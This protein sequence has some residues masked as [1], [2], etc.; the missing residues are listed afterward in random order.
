MYD[1]VEMRLL[2][3]RNSLTPEIE[4]VIADVRSLQPSIKYTR[5]ANYGARVDL[6]EVM[7][8]DAMLHVCSLN[9]KGNHKLELLHTGTK[10]WDQMMT[11]V[12]RVVRD[13]FESLEIMR[14]DPC[15]DI[16]DV[17]MDWF[18]RSVRC[19]RKRWEQQFGK[20]QVEDGQPVDVDYRD[21]SKK[22]RETIYLGRDDNFVR[23]YD[24]NA[25]TQF[26]YKREERQ[27]YRRAE[28]V[29]AQAVVA[30]NVGLSADRDYM[31][32][33]AKRV[34]ESAAR[35]YPFPAYEEWSGMWKW[36]V[37][38]RVE[39]Q[40]R[41]T[42]PLTLSK[43]GMVRDNALSFNPFD[44]MRF[45]PPREF[46]LDELRGDY[47]PAQLLKV[48][49]AWYLLNIEGWSYHE[50]F[51]FMNMKRNGRQFEQKFGELL[52]KLSEGTN[53]EKG[54]ESEQLFEGYRA[55]VRRQ[56]QIAA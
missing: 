50:F 8:E 13:D 40:M 10:T 14:L 26:R 20:I 55:S 15:V 21:I 29:L 19:D 53:N 1:K 52:R 24:K 23:I 17:G 4:D 46:S 28:K 31:R 44:K 42:I 48:V 7:E 38:T 34:K 49:G 18:S 27:H 41:G 39:R 51:Q 43:V 45:S 33:L 25:E 32:G 30:D 6:R 5:T 12:S 56:F 54:I 9:G 35:M 37:L 11:T 47:S 16:E 2:N 22:K 36:T 3:G